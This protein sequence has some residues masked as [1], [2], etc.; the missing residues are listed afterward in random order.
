MVTRLE[1]IAQLTAPGQPHE[2]IEIEAIGRRVRVFKNAP[3]NLGQ[4][5][6]EGRS[7]KTFLVYE[8]ERLTFEETWRKSCTLAHALVND[9]GV[10][11][12]DRIAI[13]MRNYPEWIIAFM[14]ATS[15]GALTVAVNALWT[16]DEMSYGIGLAEPKVAFIDQ[17]RIDRLNLLPDLPT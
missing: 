4:L 2:I 1:A 10:K 3:K 9:Y 8:D 7:D 13:A 14:A 15:I 6:A 17:E 11:K 5:Y 16:A 12:G